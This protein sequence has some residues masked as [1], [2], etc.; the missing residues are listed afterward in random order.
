MYKNWLQTEIIQKY[1]IESQRF[2]HFVNTTM[3]NNQLTKK[4]FGIGLPPM[5]RYFSLLIIKTA[6]LRYFFKKIKI[7]PQ[8]I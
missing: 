2:H 6:E 8:V 7:S 1:L 5:K 4:Y 3:S